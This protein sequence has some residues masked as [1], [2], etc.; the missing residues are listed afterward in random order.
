MLTGIGL[1]EIGFDRQL[2][3]ISHQVSRNVGY[4]SIDSQDATYL[5][6]QSVND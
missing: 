4:D 6:A 5:A 2:E 1:Y 3:R